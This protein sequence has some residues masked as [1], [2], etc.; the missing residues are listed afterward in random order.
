MM[1][2]VIIPANV[3]DTADGPI[4]FAPGDFKRVQKLLQDQTGINLASSKE[5]LVYSRLAR[6]LRPLGISNFSDYCRFVS[7]K[8]GTTEL[9]LMCDSLTTNVTKFYREGH[10]FEH[11]QTKCLPRLIDAA[12]NGARARLWSAACSSGEEPYSMALPYSL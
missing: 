11:M 4:R 7:S 3:K 9:S 6:R 12:R 5:S 2:D 1:H 10:H 8:A